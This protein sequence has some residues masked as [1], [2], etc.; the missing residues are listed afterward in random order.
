MGLALL[1][2]AC[3][4]YQNDDPSVT[5]VDSAGS[6]VVYFI[7]VGQADSALVECDGKFMLIDGGNVA[8]SDLVYTFLK[9]RSVTHLEYIVGTHAHEDHIGGLAGALNYATVGTAFCPV[10]EYD[11]KAFRS[12]VKYLGDVKITV[13]TAGDSFKLGSASVKIIAPVKQ[14]KSPNDTSIVLKITYGSTSFLFTGDAEREAE[15]DI[16]EYGAD[17]KSTVLKVGHHGSD[18]STTY[19]FL[20][21]I[22]PQ[23]AVISCGKNNNYGHPNDNTLSRLRDADV[24]VFRTDLQGTITCKSDGEKVTFTTERNG[25]KN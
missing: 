4:V 14:Y 10:T 5:A 24:T 19:P 7:D 11:T 21:E 17:L 16:L 13:P 22:M 18:T 3:E 15:A 20:R 9:D 8:D 6:F 23:Y 2:S 1:F 25:A 12:F